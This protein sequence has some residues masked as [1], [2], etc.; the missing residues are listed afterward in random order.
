MLAAVPATIAA[1]AAAE[2]NQAVRG[3]RLKGVPHDAGPDALQVAQLGDRRQLVARSQAAGLNSRGK[4]LGDLLPGRAA[5][6]RIDHQDRDVAVLGERPAGAGQVAADL[7]P[8]SGFEPLACR[9][10]EVR[11]RAPMPARC[12]DSTGHRTDSTRCPGI[13][14]RAGPRTGP[15]PRRPS[16]PGLLLCVTSPRAP[17][18]LPSDHVVN[19]SI[20]DSHA[21]C[22][23]ARFSVTAG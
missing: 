7:E 8:V 2:D 23:Q 10:Q 18:V 6:A 14:W 4:H 12:I 15:R 22:R 16:Y 3:K 1:L 5:A 19:P 17:S 9:L 13:I 11:P 21:K 20:P